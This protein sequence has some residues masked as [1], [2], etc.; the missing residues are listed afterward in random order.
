MLNYW[1][2]SSDKD[3]KTMLHLFNSKDYQWALF[4]GHLVI[5]KLL[6]GYYIKHV[7]NNVPYSHDLLRIAE[8]SNLNLTNEY[9][10]MIDLITTFNIKARYDDYKL[11]FYKKC[12]KKFTNDSIKKIKEIRKWIKEELKK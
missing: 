7:D 1:L 12:N 10:D 2:N 5:E 11:E 8:K 6:K 4:I 9:K 3:Y